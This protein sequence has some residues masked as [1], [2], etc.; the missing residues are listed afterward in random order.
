M[1]ANGTSEG[2]AWICETCGMQY[3]PA[4]TPPEECAVCSD[5][6]QYVGWEGQRWTTSATLVRT[7]RIV[8]ADEQ[9][10]TTMRMDPP[11]AIGQRA[12]LVPHAGGTVMWESLSIVTEGALAA[13]KAKGP[14]TAIAVSHPH[15]YSAMVDWSEALGD[16]PIWLH[17][18]DRDWVRR[19]SSA[20]R[21]W[22]GEHHDLTPNIRLIHL[23]GHFPG[24]AGLW[25]KDGPRPGGSLLPGDAIQVV[26]DRAHTTFMYSYPNLIPLA[27]AKV[28]E[29]RRRVAPL[30]YDDVFGFAPGRQIIGDAKDKVEGSFDRYL[31]AVAA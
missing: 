19:A 7:H 17:A 20:I 18:A 23:P 2:Q 5:E 26:A 24:S 16:V 25:W 9:G 27:P 12:V 22:D 10:A 1:D 21:F 31:Q 15:F 6:R 3:A 30:V 29:L 13:I 11:F 28:R 8:L 14:V 4:R